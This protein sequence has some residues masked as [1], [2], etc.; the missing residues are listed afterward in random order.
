MASPLFHQLLDIPNLKLLLEDLHSTLIEEEKRRKEFREWLKPDVKAEFINGEIVMHSP[1]KR[2][3]L[4]ATKYLSKLLSTYVDIHN[5]G[6]VDSEKALVSLTRNDYEP[7]ICFWKQD[8]ATE[9]HDD[10][11]I[12]PAPDLVIEILSKSTADRDRGIKYD[13]YAAHGIQEYWIIDAASQIIEVY[14]LDR[15]ALQY[16]PPIILSV[17]D[18]LESRAVSGFQVPVLAIFDK[19]TNLVALKNLLGNS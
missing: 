13:D 9:F 7:D 2:R 19:A 12:H 8:K 3:H 1:V 10:L 18:Q 5:L 15:D 16:Q 17:T 4:H 14:L 6:E 11:M